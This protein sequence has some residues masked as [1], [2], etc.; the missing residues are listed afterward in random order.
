M[1][2]LYL[3]VFTHYVNFKCEELYEDLEKVEKYHSGH[4]VSKCIDH[5]DTLS[6]DLD[7]TNQDLGNLTSKLGYV[8]VNYPAEPPKR[9]VLSIKEANQKSNPELD[10]LEDI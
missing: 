4:T 5:V 3:L 9:K 2:I 7:K 1:L 6:R 8:F 10:D